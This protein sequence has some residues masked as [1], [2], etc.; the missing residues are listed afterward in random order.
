R[1]QWG[2]LL[3]ACLRDLALERQPGLDPR[4][5]ATLDV[6]G[7]PAGL[8]ECLRR[9]SRPAAAAADEDHR[10]VARDPLRARSEVIHLDVARPA[11]VPGLPLPFAADVDDL[12]R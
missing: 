11:Q 4:S 3:R 1:A 2:G 9:H 6:V 8:A 10:A 12:P 5:Q 7:V